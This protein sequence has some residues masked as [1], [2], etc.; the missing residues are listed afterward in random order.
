MLPGRTWWL[1]V[2]PCKALFIYSIF[3]AEKGY[4]NRDHH[5]PK[6][7]LIAVYLLLNNAVLHLMSFKPLL[8]TRRPRHI[9]SRLPSKSHS[10]DNAKKIGF[11]KAVYG[12]DRKIR[13]IWHWKMAIV[14]NVI[15]VIEIQGRA[16]DGSFTRRQSM[17]Q[18]CQSTVRSSTQGGRVRGQ[19]CP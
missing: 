9:A 11:W 18:T 15:T 2:L 5:N 7:L 13:L 1:V 12:Q 4:V 19:I 6:Q 10:T 14:W 16:R 8:M 17:L 3:V